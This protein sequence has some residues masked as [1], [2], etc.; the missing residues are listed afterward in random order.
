M[1]RGKGCQGSKGEEELDQHYGTEDFRCKDLQLLSP[2]T[3]TCRG[4]FKNHFN[5]SIKC[6]TGVVRCLL[7]HAAQ[8]T[9]IYVCVTLSIR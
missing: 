1:G 5:G 4:E 6:L 3:N 7:S 9:G 8:A 2:G